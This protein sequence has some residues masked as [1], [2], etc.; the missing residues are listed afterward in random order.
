MLIIRLQAFQE[1]A[2]GANTY[3][4]LAYSLDAHHGLSVCELEVDERVLSPL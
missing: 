4:Q 3:N 1:E 2:G